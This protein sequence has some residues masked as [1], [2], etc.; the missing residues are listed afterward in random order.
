MATIYVD[1][2]AVG[3][4][5]GADWTN[6][7]TT[8][9]VALTAWTTSDVIWVAHN[10]SETLTQ[11][12]TAGNS[13]ATNVC[14]IFSLYSGTDTY[15]KATAAQIIFDADRDAA[16]NDYLMFYGV[17]FDCAG[18]DFYQLLSGGFI[19]VD[20]P[21]ENVDKLGASEI[22]RVFHAKNCEWVN[23]NVDTHVHGHSGTLCLIAPHGDFSTRR[24]VGILH[25]QA[26]GEIV[27]GDF[28]S[29]TS[30]DPFFD[31][32]GSGSCT[33]STLNIYG[34][35]LPQNADITDGDATN[36]PS[37]CG[38]LRISGSDQYYAFA[39]PR[40]ET[41]ADTGVFYDSGWLDEEDGNRLSY[42]IT[43][44]SVCTEHDILTL[45][46]SKAHMSLLR[47]LKQ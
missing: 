47:V 1:S 45:G 46:G 36:S 13:S 44:L 25:G 16:N 41:L 35:R 21:L 20:C 12:F 23:S 10:H 3:G 8:L 40:G 22:S 38:Y 31:A 26:R 19:L 6:A 33:S 37:Q 4:G 2:S 30:S 14:P 27:G 18:F 15:E 17:Y 43:A 34:T 39:N 11:D 29:D 42:K 28:S 24:S 7:Y 32:S 9:Q 5:T